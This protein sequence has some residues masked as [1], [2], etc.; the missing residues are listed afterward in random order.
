MTTRTSRGQVFK[1]AEL[2]D[3]V[4]DVIT[5][6]PDHTV[7]SARMLFAEMRKAGQP[8]R[9]TSIR[10][11]VDDLLV[12]GR[13]TEVAGKRGAKGYRAVL[14]A[15]QESSD[16]TSV[17][18]RDRTASPLRGVGRSGT[19]SLRPRPGR[20]GTQWDAVSESATHLPPRHLFNHQQ[21]EHDMTDQLTLF[22]D[23]LHDDHTM[24]CHWGGGLVLP[25][26][27]RSR[28]RMPLVP[29]ARRRRPACRLRQI[30][31]TRPKK[32][33]GML[34]PGQQQGDGEPTAAQRERL[35]ELLRTSGLSNQ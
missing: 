23:A 22:D 14:T 5:A 10:S 28:R 34:F 32:Y 11:A 3:I 16:M 35:L 17:R 30:W 7:A 4:H 6:L 12:A 21:K 2:A 27:P 15:S 1:L 24:P 9:D 31:A 25:R 33:P 26:S 8:F 13:L 19:Q 18:V 29:R 20:S